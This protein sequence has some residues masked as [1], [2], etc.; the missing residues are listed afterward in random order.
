MHKYAYKMNK[1]TKHKNKPGSPFL[2]GSRKS[3]EAIPE[4]QE[5]SPE[6]LKTKEARKQLSKRKHNML[7]CC[8]F[9]F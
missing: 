4:K 3:P 9:T 2:T 1:Y 5:E 8:L 7:L 6:G